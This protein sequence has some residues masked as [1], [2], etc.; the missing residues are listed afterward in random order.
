MTAARPSSW[1]DRLRRAVR[2]ARR[3][4]LVLHAAFV[5]LFAVR[6]LARDLLIAT[7][8]LFVV[9]APLVLA[10]AVLAGIP[11][12]GGWKLRGG[13]SA[14]LLAAILAT[15]FVEQPRLVPFLVRDA[16]A[17]AGRSVRIVAWNVMNYNRG[18]KPVIEGY[19]QDDPDVV[20]LLEGTYRRGAPGFLRRG[21]GPSYE[22]IG[23]RQMAMGSRLPVLEAE[24][25]T[26]R[27]RLRIFRAKFD[28]GG[29]PLVVLLADVA[30]PP[31]S[32]TREMYDELAGIVAREP[33]PFVLVG[34]FNTPRG[35]WHL[36]RA[37]DGLRDFYTS[38]TGTRWL[39]SWPAEMPIYQLDQAFCSPDLVP[40][41][42]DLRG[43]AGSD[44][45]RQS[46][47]FTLPE[48]AP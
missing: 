40:V 8:L 28:A 11:A 48:S 37:T 26:C 5:V 19:K 4:C 22:W 29:S 45:L 42:A 47:A 32:D 20:C 41:S 30:R 23:T 24:E 34:D 39:A 33:G 14:V 38:C 3:A 31:R 25:I 44:H 36:G 46:I 7:E 17:P 43:A 10:P 9:P 2:F 35:S 16:G 6:I 21:L 18:E 12:S 15:L 1:R 13:L 27:T